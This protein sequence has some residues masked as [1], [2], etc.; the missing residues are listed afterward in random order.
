MACTP[1]AGGVSVS[2]SCTPRKNRRS[3]RP[4]KPANESDRVR[5]VA[6]DLVFQLRQ[7]QTGRQRLRVQIGCDELE[8]VVMGRSTERRARP[9][10]STFF[11]ARSVGTVSLADDEFAGRGRLADLPFREG[12]H[13]GG[14]AIEDR[15]DIDLS[16]WAA[17]LIE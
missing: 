1:C 7:R 13:I 6:L 3:L 2:A 15:I 14:N 11:A 16:G 8:Y 5:D 9:T 17:F 10:V 12:S 4:P